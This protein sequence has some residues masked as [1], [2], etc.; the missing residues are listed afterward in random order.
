MQ[1][2]KQKKLNLEVDVFIMHG[3]FEDVNIRIHCGCTYRVQSSTN[4]SPSRMQSYKIHIILH[5]ICRIYYVHCRIPNSN[6][7]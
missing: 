3:V 4:S 1:L 5:S 6:A 2:L 7:N